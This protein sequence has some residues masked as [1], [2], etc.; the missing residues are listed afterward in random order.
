MLEPKKNPLHELM[1]G[2]ITLISSANCVLARLWRLM[3]FQLNVRASIWETLLTTYTEACKAHMPKDKALNLKGN[4]SKGMAKDVLSWGRLCQG[5][6]VFGFEET[7]L[8]LELTDKDVTKDVSIRLP[9]VHGEGAGEALK[10]LW[11]LIGKTF[12]E[13]I[14][15]WS[16]CIEI[17]VQRCKE[18]YGDESSWTKGNVTRALCDTSITWSMF[19][20][21]LI[22]LD[23]EAIGIELIVKQRGLPDAKAVRLDLKRK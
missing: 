23:F 12:P 13:R 8:K 9:T 15:N 20:R 2:D 21:G 16:E 18:Q 5:L 3:L 10:L 4:I 19:Y 1:T 17:Y 11:D 6:S 7:I 14:E 22:I